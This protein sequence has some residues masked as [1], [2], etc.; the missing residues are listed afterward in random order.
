MPYYEFTV[1]GD[2]DPD[3]LERETGLEVTAAV[4]NVR[5]GG[6]L[7]DRA[8]LYGIIERLYRLGLDVVSVERRS[9][10]HAR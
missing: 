7:V 10:R 8:A 3:A 4:R 1:S 9:A 6:D 2:V 5:A